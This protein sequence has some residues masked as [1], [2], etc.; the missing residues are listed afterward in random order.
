MVPQAVHLEMH[1]KKTIFS[2]N[3]PVHVTDEKQNNRKGREGKLVRHMLLYLHKYILQLEQ[4]RTAQDTQQE[5]KFGQMVLVA[6][7]GLLYFT[8]PL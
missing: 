2:P 3:A 7:V 8:M 1:R 4:S 6:V 5:E